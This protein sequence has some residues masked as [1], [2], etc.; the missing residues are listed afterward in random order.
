MPF[1]QNHTKVKT[2][3][4]NG[5]PPSVRKFYIHNT[6]NEPKNKFVRKLKP[7]I[8]MD[9]G[10]KKLKELISEPISLLYYRQPENIHENLP[11]G[12]NR[13]K[14]INHWD[15]FY[16]FCHKL[17]LLH[18]AICWK[19]DLVNDFRHNTQIVRLL[20]EMS[21]SETKALLSKYISS[22]KQHTA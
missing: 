19:F 13:I 8:H 12:T 9:D 4:V 18:E 14:E 3:K 22:K 11:I 10:L 21:A 2:I 5:N 17:K 16:D 7:H 6:R 15:E 1:F 20:N